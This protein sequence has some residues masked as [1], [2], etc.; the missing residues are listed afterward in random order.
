MRKPV[1]FCLLDAQPGL[2]RGVVGPGL[3]ETP[4]NGAQSI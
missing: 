4:S 1:R 2:Y 3:D